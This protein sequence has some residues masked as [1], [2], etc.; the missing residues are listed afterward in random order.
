MQ[1]GIQEYEVKSSSHT[2]VGRQRFLILSNDT[3]IVISMFDLQPVICIIA[4]HRWT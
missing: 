4:M 3:N 2:A 1:V